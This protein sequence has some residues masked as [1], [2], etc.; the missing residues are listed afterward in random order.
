MIRIAAVDA[1]DEKVAALLH[2]LQLETLPGTEP[3]DVSDGHWWI[4]YDG[5]LPIAFAGVSQSSKWG[6]AGYLCR[7]GVIRS[8]RGKGLQKRLIRIRERKARQ[9]LWVWLIT[10]TFNNPASSNSLIS[11]G[12]RLFKPTNPWGFDGALYWRKKLAGK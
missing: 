2:Y 1:S 9:N 4:A 3:Y 12:Y 6:D 7:S 11:C 8:H 10:D 5:K